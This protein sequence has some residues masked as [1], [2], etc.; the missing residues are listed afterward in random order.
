MGDFE[1]FEKKLS[2]RALRAI[3]GHWD[4]ARVGRLMPGWDDLA[5]GVL[6]RHFALLWGFQFEPSSQEFVGRLA[7]THV[8]EW[9]GANFWGARLREIHPPP[10][11]ERAQLF[12]SKVLTVPAAGYCSGS[13]FTVAGHTVKGERIALPL[14]SDG[15]TGEGVLG[16]SYFEPTHAAGPVELVF[17]NMEWFAL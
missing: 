9:L 4:N 6:E 8:K 13:L 14:A 12:L 16:A 10:V 17:E 3:A 1:K 15:K 7:G 5:P 2:S 11:Y